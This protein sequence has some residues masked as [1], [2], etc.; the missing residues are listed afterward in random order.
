M[1]TYMPRIIVIL[2]ALITII[3]MSVQARAAGALRPLI[4]DLD[5]GGPRLCGL[6]FDFERPNGVSILVTLALQPRPNQ[7]PMASM[8][9]SARLI[10]PQGRAQFL[11]VEEA[12]L[13]RE[14]QAAFASY[15][16]V[17]PHTI[18][19]AI[20]A[21]A[22]NAEEVRNMI[23]A[24]RAGENVTLDHKLGGEK[25]GFALVSQGL[26]TAEE[27]E[28]LGHCLQRLFTSANPS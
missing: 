9:V 16:P 25:R 7:K 1:L 14:G 18:E 15:K 8:I 5:G 11:T 28:R 13:M 27:N 10:E 23:E 6:A 3:A 24:V 21:V 2:A 19:G 22:R 20:M 4:Y 26:L 12:T 17:R